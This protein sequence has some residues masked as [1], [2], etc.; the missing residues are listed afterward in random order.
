M[1]AWERCAH[2]RGTGRAGHASRPT[3]CPCVLR[4]I[5]RRCLERY[6]A[7]SPLGMRAMIYRIDFDLAAKYTLTARERAAFERY[8]EA[9]APW[10]QCNGLLALDR[11]AFF[12]WV[13]ATEVRLGRA[14]LQREIFPFGPY[15]EA[16]GRRGPWQ[17]RRFARS[18]L[19]MRTTGESIALAVQYAVAA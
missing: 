17:D 16:G 19:P 15:F 7:S 10:S 4:K 1:L 12:T 14:L 9:A 13:Y 5:F 3:Y 18:R 2:C 6:H 8:F 11:G